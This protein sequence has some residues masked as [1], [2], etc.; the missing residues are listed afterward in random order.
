MVATAAFF[1]G[2]EAPLPFLKIIPSWIWFL[3]K[4]YTGV[5]VFMWFR[6]TFPRLRVDRLMAF[7]WKFLIPWSFAALFIAAAWAVLWK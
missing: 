5:F 1:G 7:N 4:T 6:W 2:G 3:A